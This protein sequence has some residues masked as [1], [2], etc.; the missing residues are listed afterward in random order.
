MGRKG[1]EGT[2]GQLSFFFFFFFFFLP[3]KKL[4][5]PE[6]NFYIFICATDL[7]CFKLPV[8]AAY[9]IYVPLPNVFKF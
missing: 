7:P 6:T 3:L 4:R 2:E 5:E 1:I 9:A 8:K